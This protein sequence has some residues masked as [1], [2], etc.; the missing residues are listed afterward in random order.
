MLEVQSKPQDRSTIASD[1]L[2]NKI[3][4]SD[5]SAISIGGEAVRLG[6]DLK[7]LKT[8][9]ET[10][11]ENLKLN[12]TIKTLDGDREISFLEKERIP[13]SAWG[14]Q[15]LTIESQPP[16]WNDADATASIQFLYLP[17]T[18]SENTNL[19]SWPRVTIQPSTTNPFELELNNFKVS[20]LN[21]EFQEITI[22]P[23]MIDARNNTFEILNI[24][25]ANDEI[26]EN[27]KIARIWHLGYLYYDNQIP[28]FLRIF[29]VVAS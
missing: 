20:E 17:P 15:N 26:K 27:G 24:I 14:D 19:G 5:S 22:Q 11:N 6:G 9:L 18:T 3:V 4:D 2:G 28:K 13:R 10:S 25:R 7:N 8:F 16:L 1:G 29:T 23:F 21:L 12:C